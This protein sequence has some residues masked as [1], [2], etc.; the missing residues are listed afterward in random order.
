VVCPRDRRDSDLMFFKKYF[1]NNTTRT[2]LKN[3]KR[4]LSLLSLS[5]IFTREKR[6]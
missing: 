3:K 6:Q 4:S 1:Y 2:M 5:R